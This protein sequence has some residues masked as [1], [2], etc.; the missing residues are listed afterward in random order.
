MRIFRGLAKCRVMIHH[1]SMANH[2]QLI[3]YFSCLQCETVYAASQEE[4]PEPCS[5]DFHCRRCGASVHKW[6]GP[7]LSLLEACEPQVT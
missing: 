5:G 4:Q 6:T 1:C 7:R 2:F 3:V